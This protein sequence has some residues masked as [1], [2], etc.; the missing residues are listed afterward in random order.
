[1]GGGERSYGF[2]SQRASMYSIV[3]YLM[4]VAN[5]MKSVR[6][7]ARLF[8][9]PLSVVE[10]DKLLPLVVGQQAEDSSP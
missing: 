5:A 9:T 10:V 3:Q 7:L 4:C 2:T 8:L 1:M 6:L